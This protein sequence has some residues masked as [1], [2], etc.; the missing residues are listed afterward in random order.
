MTWLAFS[1]ALFKALL[2]MTMA[3]VLIYTAAWFAGSP[4]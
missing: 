3:L 1:L 4:L 2:G